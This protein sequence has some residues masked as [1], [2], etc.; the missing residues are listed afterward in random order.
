[1]QILKG[2]T[3]KSHITMLLV[4]H[5]KCITFFYMNENFFVGNPIGENYICGTEYSLEELRGFIINVLKKH[6]D[7]RQYSFLII[8]TNL[9]E[10]T[11]VPFGELLEEELKQYDLSCL[12]MLVTCR[13]D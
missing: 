10:K 9:P 1:M 4:E 2:K 3:G 12:D 5:S 6:K 7:C 8:Y 13:P 11:V